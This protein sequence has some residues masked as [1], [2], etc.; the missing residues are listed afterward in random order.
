MNPDDYNRIKG[1]PFFVGESVL[2]LNVV[3]SEE[4]QPGTLIV[5]DPH[6]LVRLAKDADE[7]IGVAVAPLC[8]NCKQPKGE[9]GPEGKCLFES[10]TYAT[11]GTVI[12]RLN[13]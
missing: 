9:H 4:L 6:G 12:V 7:T 5:V 10:T 3:A 11:D 1:S 13:V 8:V 2:G